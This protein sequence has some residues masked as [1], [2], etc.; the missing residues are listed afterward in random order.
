[1]GRDDTACEGRLSHLAQTI[2]RATVTQ[3]ADNFDDGHGSNVSEHTQK[4]IY[5]FLWMFKYSCQVVFCKAV[6]EDRLGGN[7]NQRQEKKKRFKL[8]AAG[9]STILLF[10]PQLKHKLN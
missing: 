10:R 4:Y 8:N 3:I 5:I 9:C 2:R 7:T 1:M 6:L